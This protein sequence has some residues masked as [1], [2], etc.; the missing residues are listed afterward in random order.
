MYIVAASN[1]ADM[2]KNKPQIFMCLFIFFP[3]RKGIPII[4]EITNQLAVLIIAYTSADENS[5]SAD[6]RYP[7]CMYSFAALA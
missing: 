7:L 3:K 6:T 5:V 2:M 1:K 4:S